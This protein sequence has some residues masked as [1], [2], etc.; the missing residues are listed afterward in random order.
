MNNLSPK[1][2]MIQL[3]EQC[4]SAKD[5]N[6][7]H[8]C[9]KIYKSTF[10]Y[11]DFY[12]VCMNSLT[13]SAGPSVTLIYIKQ[14]SEATQ[15]CLENVKTFQNYKNLDIIC[16]SADNLLE[17]FCQC[18]T[19]VE[20]EYICFFDCKHKYDKNRISLLISFLK[21]AP[22][23]NGI[24]C[25]R[26]FIDI[27]DV[28]IAHPDFIYQD[29]L[30]NHI[31][32]GKQLLTYSLANTVNLYGDLSTLL[33]SADYA[34]KLRLFN[35]CIPHS[36]QC[37]ALLYQ[38]LY[39]AN[40][41]YTY[42]PLASSI[43]TNTLIDEELN[44]DYQKLLSDY[45]SQNFFD[46][47]PVTACDFTKTENFISCKKDITFFYTDMGEYYNL[48]PIAD[49]AAA[50]GYKITFTDNTLA[51]AEIGIYCQHV[52]HPEN[53]KFSVILL[54]D[55]AQGH[56]RWPNLW[57]LERWNKFDIGIVPGDFWAD[58]WRQCSCQ[59]YANPRCGTYELGYPK[60]D[61][62][63]SPELLQHVEELRN[64]FH[65]KYDVSILYAPSWEND[66][67]EDDFIKALSSL[68]VNLLIKQAHWSEKYSNIIE[69]IKNM[70]AL[71]EGKYD[72]VYYIE[73]EESIMTAL[74]MCD[75]VV[76]DES[77][78]MAE[79][80]MFGKTSIAVTDWLIPDTTP[81]RYAVVP[82][83]Y[84]IKSTKANLRKDME[85]LISFPESFSYVREKGSRVF[86]NVG[87]SRADILDAIEYFTSNCSDTPKDFMSKRLTSKYSICNLWN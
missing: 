82:M 12:M 25:T 14:S 81:S 32:E 33:I 45:E 20:S 64:K 79:A 53:S 10:G 60:S 3:I 74:A 85:Q 1:A 24:I 43:L 65:L 31:F 26:N 9:L 21:E 83:D 28:T 38:L 34:K 8:E 72:N 16:L 86:S 48:K 29:M 66:G 75:Y 47:S 19:S 69:N 56:N 17:E 78:V 37:T 42:L 6:T 23:A 30:D 39:S 76:S 2:Q 36:M 54:H 70:R 4:L 57:E 59:Y 77:S 80:L 49:E 44:T 13:V 35:I 18:I 50:R 22:T 58:L 52:C 41:V 68:N 27:N 87:Y 62:V 55:L 84:V 61:L 51:T 15:T 71:H 67:K 7:T 40:I 73:P 46:I 63:S 11:D 5:Y